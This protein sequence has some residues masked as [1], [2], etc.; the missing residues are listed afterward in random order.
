MS[1]SRTAWI[2]ASILTLTTGVRAESPK[3]VEVIAGSLAVT[4]LPEVQRVTGTV[5]V[6]DFPDFPPVVVENGAEPLAVTIGDVLRT[7]PIQR[8]PHNE[9]LLFQVNETTPAEPQAIR[10]GMVVTDLVVANLTNTAICTFILAKTDLLTGEPQPLMV[11]RLGDREVRSFHFRA[12]FT[13]LEVFGQPSLFVEVK[14]ATLSSDCSV[15][16]TYSGFDI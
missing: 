3:E 5:E 12:G 1:T 11:L 2:L 6:S 10:T 15:G 16:V 8:F 13:S 9:F 14:R 7:D 4:N